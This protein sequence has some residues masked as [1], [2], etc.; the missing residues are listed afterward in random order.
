MAIDKRIP[1]KLNKDADYK[2]LKEV[3]AIDMINVRV[4]HSDSGDE[5]VLKAAFG[6]ATVTQSL[7]SGDNLC[8]GS[9]TVEQENALYFFV[10]NSNSNHG[11]FR[12][13]IQTDEAKEIMSTDLFDF[14]NTDFIRVDSTI[15]ADGDTHLLFSTTRGEPFMVNASRAVRN[16]YDF[17]GMSDELILEH[18]TLSKKPPL[19]PPTFLFERD[20][21]YQR[22]NFSDKMFQFACQYVYDDGQVSALSPF[23]KIAYSDS[24]LFSSDVGDP[25]IFG[26]NKVNVYCEHSQADV[27]KIKFFARQGNS[28]TFYE[29]GETDNNNSLS[30]G[31]VSTIEFYND[32][33]YKALGANEENKIVDGIPQDVNALAISN[34]RA[35]LANYKEGRPNVET[36]VSFDT[37]Q[38]TV[39]AVYNIAAR[40]LRIG[41]ATVSTNAQGDAYFTQST[42]NTDR[43]GVQFD[44]SELP[45][46]IDAGSILTISFSINFDK[47]LYS[48]AGSS[49][50]SIYLDD[51]QGNSR[52]F[53]YTPNASDGFESYLRFYCKPIKIN[54]KIEIGSNTSRSDVAALIASKLNKAYLFNV[55]PDLDKINNSTRL[56]ATAQDDWRFWFSGVLAI[57]FEEAAD[58]LQDTD[59]ELLSLN[60]GLSGSYIFPIKA[61]NATDNAGRAFTNA[62]GIPNQF[63]ITSRS[64]STNGYVF[65][66]MNV[67]LSS[68]NVYNGE[69]VE[70]FKGNATHSFGIVYKD[71]RGRRSGVQ[72]CGDVY[73]EDNLNTGGNAIASRINMTVKH[74][75]PEWADRWSVVYGLNDKYEEYLQYSVAEAFSKDSDDYEF[76]TIYV[77]LRTLE[78]KPNSFIDSKNAN[79]S[80]EFADGD[81][82]RVLRYRQDAG[83]GE[84]AYV[85]ED[86]VEFDIIDYK[87]IDG[88]E[89]DLTSIDTQEIDYR[90]T[91]WFLV[92][93]NKNLNKWKASNVV[94][95]TDRWKYDTVVE[96]YRPKKNTEEKVYYEIGE[97]RDITASGSIRYHE[98]EYRDYSNEGDTISITVVDVGNNQFQYFSDSKLYVGEVVSFTMNSVDYTKTIASVVESAGVSTYGWYFITFESEIPSDSAVAG[99]YSATLSNVNTV[100][101]LNG[102]GCFL[103]PRL[104]QVCPVTDY[105]RSDTNYVKDTLYQSQFVES[106]GLSDFFDSNSYSIGR[107]SVVIDEAK[108]VNRKSS[109]T[110]SDPYVLDSRRFNLSSFNNSL[111]NWVDYDNGYGGI[112]HIGDNGDSFTL[113]F[114][115]KV[116]VVPVGRNLVQYQ[117][118]D[119]NATV[120]DQ[121][122]SSKPN[123]YAGEWGVNNSPESIAKDDMGRYYYVD[124]RQRKVIKIGGGGQKDISDEDMSSFFRTLLSGFDSR[125]NT[126][127]VLGEFDGE[128]DEYILS[129]QDSRSSTL[130]VYLT[131]PASGDADFSY[132]VPINSDDDIYLL[133]EEEPSQM[134]TWGEEERNWENLCENWEDWWSGVL[135]IDEI[136]ENPTIYFDDL[137][138]SLPAT[139]GVVVTT[140]DYDFYVKGTYTFSTNVLELEAMPSCDYNFG[141][142]VDSASDENG[143][144]VAYST[145]GNYWT[146]RYS[147]KPDMMA[148]ASDTLFSFEEGQMYKHSSAATPANFAG[149]QYTVDIDLAF[150]Y[151]PVKVKFYKALSVDGNS[152]AVVY[153]SNEDQYT[154]IPLT[155]WDE[156]ER[157]WY[158]FVPNDE[159]SQS[160]SNYQFIGRFDE[161]ETFWILEFGSWNDSAT[162]IDTEV[163]VD[164]PIAGAASASG[165]T[166]TSRIPRNVPKGSPLYY[167]PSATVVAGQASPDTNQTTTILASTATAGIV[168]AKNAISYSGTSPFSSGDM[169]FIKKDGVVDGDDMRSTWMK[170]DFT[171]VASSTLEIHALNAIY[172]TSQLHNQLG[173]GGDG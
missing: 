147:F 168:V 85:Q 113:F 166:F 142:L 98:S 86:G 44:L 99:S 37:I 131:Y 104:I 129:I 45:D 80:Y 73:I 156:R 95:G 163:W 23:S 101:E 10:W 133:Y 40:N 18:I 33:V 49:L 135:W 100:V 127:K 65:E 143:D 167:I 170:A 102:V 30:V 63:I 41:T 1:R 60:A 161:L 83:N 52:T 26:D 11:I 121:V 43:L 123:W 9:H 27:S 7:R 2:R 103:R 70:V 164:T 88:S 42:S 105:D 4:N 109:M 46:V 66:N 20:D 165:M 120:S 25:N 169:V 57:G 89:I 94:T 144:T 8:I 141:Q 96:I 5:G 145:K 69:D 114:E 122:V 77:S 55:E 139:A 47:I 91:G 64:V 153:C 6:N 116:G 134:P 173:E 159:G 24:A 75:P 58:S 155:M 172:Q 117:D 72:D 34:N 137:G 39:G 150:N 84:Y 140:R 149:T 130:E 106:M 152:A 15:D 136:A 19:S 146:T 79:V 38:N 13:N 124:T 138:T 108:R 31:S 126:T 32:K 28:G 78:G 29:I 54:E 74:D 81:K 118:G 97:E 36:D 67:D 148:F 59:A 12:Y 22:N 93:K 3:E 48:G 107:P 171:F 35:W 21:S 56:Y 92:L 61:V 157:Q 112:N 125:V 162:W 119:A 71:N 132:T 110:W 160:W 90:K 111:A 16:G 154:N 17:T 68:N 115:R 82:V 158:T 76:D 53:N 50:F 151:D 51:D 62:T 87:Y 14:Q 128:N